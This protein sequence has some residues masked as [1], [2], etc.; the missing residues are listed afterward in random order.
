MDA[1]RDHSKVGYII[2]E[3]GEWLKKGFL[4]S[5]NER[6]TKTPRDMTRLL[7]A[8][9]KEVKTDDPRM[10]GLCH[11]IMDGI[12]VELHKV[13]AE[14]LMDFLTVMN[15]NSDRFNQTDLERV[16]QFGFLFL[17]LLGRDDYNRAVFS[18]RNGKN[19]S[20]LG[21]AGKKLSLSSFGAS[22]IR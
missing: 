17:R 13:A 19:L 12:V 3:W 21:L 20:N 18:V 9:S 8:I 14:R 5:P 1:L 2:C 22:R 11:Y 4:T 7:G 10:R 16:R 15:E 6:F